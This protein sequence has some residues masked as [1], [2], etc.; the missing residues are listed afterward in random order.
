MCDNYTECEGCVE[1]SRGKSVMARETLQ[2]GKGLFADQNIKA[3][4]CIFPYDGKVSHRRP[5]NR[6]NY[7]VQIKY[8]ENAST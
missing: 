5:R 8:P 2:I 7:V 1:G 4:D 3:G 6:C